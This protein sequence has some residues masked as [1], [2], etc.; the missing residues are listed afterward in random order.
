MFLKRIILFWVG[1]EKIYALINVIETMI[2]STPVQIRKKRSKLKY[3]LLQ[4]CSILI[5]INTNKNSVKQR[6]K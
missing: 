4:F 2:L 5:A 6:S 3:I 1:K